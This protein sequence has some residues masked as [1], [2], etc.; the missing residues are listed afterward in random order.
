MDAPLEAKREAQR[1]NDAH[2]ATK[3]VDCEV[4]T[5]VSITECFFF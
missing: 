3:K 1:A 5:S 2:R 4:P